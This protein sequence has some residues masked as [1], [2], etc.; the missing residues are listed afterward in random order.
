ML[1]KIS[2]LSDL[3]PHYANVRKYSKEYENQTG[4]MQRCIQNC[5]E[6]S[7][8]YEE[9]YAK[10]FRSR[11]ESWQRNYRKARRVRSADQ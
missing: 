2:Q 8:Q 3:L 7:A 1:K 9:A 4:A 10:S 6:A 11:R 5:Q